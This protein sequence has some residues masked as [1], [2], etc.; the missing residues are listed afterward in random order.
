[1]PLVCWVVMVSTDIVLHLQA[2]AQHSVGDNH[3]GEEQE[4]VQ[5]PFPGHS[6]SEDPQVN[7]AGHWLPST[8]THTHTHTHT[9]KLHKQQQ[10][11]RQ[12]D[13][14]WEKSCCVTCIMWCSMVCIECCEHASDI[15]DLPL[16][17]QMQ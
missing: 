17:V 6:Q 9:E 10:T 4:E 1:M 14:H 12:V 2:Q 15:I 11:S 13:G 3:Q 7:T 16:H 5:P 8:L